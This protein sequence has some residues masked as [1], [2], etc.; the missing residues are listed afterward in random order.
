MPAEEGFP[1]SLPSK[2]AQFYERAGMVKTLAGDDASVTIIGSVS[3]PGGDFSEP[4]TQHTRR[5]IRC[6]WALNTTLANARHYPA[7]VGPVVWLRLA[8]CGAALDAPGAARQSGDLVRMFS[9][10][11]ETKLM[12]RSLIAALV[13][14][15]TLLTACGDSEEKD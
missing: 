10:K 8:K 3:P 7:I 13:T 12:I 4:V 9:L 11:M 15:T 2:L 1:A 6:Y 5:F 14:A